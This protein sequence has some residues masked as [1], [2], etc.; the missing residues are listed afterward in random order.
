MAEVAL[1]SMETT[2][3]NKKALAEGQAAIQL[4]TDYFGPSSYRRMA[5]TQQTAC[6]FGQSWPQ[7]VWIPICYFFMV[8]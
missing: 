3:L 1:G 8:C 7:L 2:S 5:H 4:Y 6:N